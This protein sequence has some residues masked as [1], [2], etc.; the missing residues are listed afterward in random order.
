MAR[1]SSLQGRDTHVAGRPKETV[2]RQYSQYF[3]PEFDKQL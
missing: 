2:I 1:E 3:V